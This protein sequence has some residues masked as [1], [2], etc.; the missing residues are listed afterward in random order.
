MNVVGRLYCILG[1]ILCFGSSV[2]AEYDNLTSS[3]NHP[4]LNTME[5]MCLAN[6]GFTVAV[7]YIPSTDEFTTD[8]WGRIATVPYNGTNQPVIENFSWKVMVWDSS[9]ALHSSPWDGNYYN[10][11][12]SL[13]T[14]SELQGI[15]YNGNQETRI[16]RAQFSLPPIHLTAGTEYWFSIRAFGSGGAYNCG[17]STGIAKIQS[18]SICPGA[19]LGDSGKIFAGNEIWWPPDHWNYTA[20]V[21]PSGYSGC[22]QPATKLS[23]T[24]AS[25]FGDLNCDG[26]TNLLDLPL[27]YLAMFDPNGF[28]SQSQG[29]SIFNADFNSD[30]VID[31]ADYDAFLSLL[32]G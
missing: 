25:I 24:I 27:F 32:P 6:N 19:G 9:S 22:K 11:H 5:D 3:N 17:P 13:P 16:Y 14:S 7:R 28:T 29:C 31:G 2:L 8:F 15:L 21:Y 18:S 12:Y 1:G 26:F 30:E 10:G 23:T 20:N 4:A